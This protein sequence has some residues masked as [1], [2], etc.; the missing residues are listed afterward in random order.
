MSGADNVTQW[1]ANL[2]D[3]DDRAAEFL[4][5]K[6]FA[7]LVRFARKKLEYMPRREADEEDVA[8]SAMHSF[9]QGMANRR[10]PKVDDREDLWKLLITITARKAYGQM[11]AARTEKRGSGQVRGESV[12][13]R[14]EGE[15]DVAG[16]GQVL[17]TEPTPELANMVAEDCQH[18]LAL[19]GDETLHQVAVHKLEGY[20]NE[21]I[22]E[23]LGC[24]TRTVER[25]LE[26]IRDK[27]SREDLS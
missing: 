10:F 6:Y 12:F 20:T 1:I 15:D 22:A 13:V 26:R 8:L 27:W 17:G 2:S 4:W 16:I 24:V 3:G 19:L 7:K 25:K 18:L 14:T 23:S 5:E 9:C 11:R 21:E